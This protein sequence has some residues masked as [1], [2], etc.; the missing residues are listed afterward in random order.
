MLR[1]KPSGNLEHF[2][3]DTVDREVVEVP[4]DYSSSCM[5]LMQNQGSTWQ[6]KMISFK[7]VSIDFN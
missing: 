5:I 2:L 7:V 3:I 6:L 4:C 1:I